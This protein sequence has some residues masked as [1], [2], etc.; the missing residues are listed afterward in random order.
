MVRIFLRP[1]LHEMLKT[2]S[3]TFHIAVWTSGKLKNNKPIIDRIY[4]DFYF[5]WCQEN[6]Q[7]SGYGPNQIIS[8]PLEK[9][10]HEYPQFNLANTIILDDSPAKVHKNNK[11][12]AIFIPTFSV[13]DPNAVN[14]NA[15]MCVVKYLQQFVYEDP[16]DVCKFLEINPFSEQK[17]SVAE[18]KKKMFLVTQQSEKDNVILDRWKNNH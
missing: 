11:S 13:S 3:D 5:T 8:K 15:L 10:F 1:F 6:C 14:D 2:L 12:N 16:T 4:D 17:D 9:I 18:Q 7:I